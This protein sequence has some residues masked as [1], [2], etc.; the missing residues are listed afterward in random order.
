MQTQEKCFLLLLWNNF[1]EKNAKLFV[2]ALVK[3]EILTSRKVLCRKSLARVISW[4]SSCFAKRCFPKYWF[5]SLKCQL[6]RKQ[7]WHSLFVKIFQHSADKEMGNKV[8]LSSFELKNF[9]GF[10]LAW[11][12]REKQNNLSQ[13]FMFTYSHANTLLGQSE[14]AHYL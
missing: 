7:N 8:N 9:F 5:S 12:A 13:P 1:P 14:R 11:L 3:R 4:I 6:K 2:M 10:V